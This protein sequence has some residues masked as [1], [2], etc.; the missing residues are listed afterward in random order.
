M[1]SFQA[2]TSWESARKSENKN[3]R[4]DQ[5]LP[6]PLKRIPKKQQK[7]SKNE[8]TLLWLLFKPKLVGKGRERVKIK[9][10]VLI[11]SYPTRYREFQ[12]NSKKIEKMKKHHYGHFSSLNL[13]GKAKKERK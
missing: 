11:F 10:I 6:D 13:L 9:I 12:K 2:K 7:N 1:A 4:S 5:F 8:K 3:Y